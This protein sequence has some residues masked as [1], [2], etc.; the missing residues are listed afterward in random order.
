MIFNRRKKLRIISSLVILLTMVAVPLVGVGDQPAQAAEPGQLAPMNPAFL[1]FW[2]NPRP[3]PFYGYIPPPVDLSHL[4]E[5]PVERARELATFPSSFDWRDTGKV[6]SVKNQNSCGT[7][8]VHGTLAAVESKVLIEESIS[9][10]PDY[11]EQNLACCTDPAWVYL[12][13]NRCMGGGWSWLAAD[14]LTKKGT[15]LESCQPY[16]KN[17]ID[18][19][20][21][22]DSCQ[23]IKMVTD[24]RIIAN[25]ATS[26]DVIEPIKNAI[27]NHGPLAMSYAADDGSH[28][29][30]GNIYYWP[31]CP[32][33]EVNHLVCIIGWDDSIAWPGGAGSGAWIVKNSWGTDWEANGY[34]YL[35]YGSA[36]MC[37]VASLD[38]KDYDPNEKVYYWDEAGTVF[39]AGV[40]CEASSAWM[41]NIFSSTQDG[42]LSHVDFWTTSNNAQYEIYV[43][44]D[45]NISD[46]L[47]NLAASQSGSCDEFGYYSTPLTSPVSLTN[48]QPFTIAVKTTTP[49]YVYPIPVEMQFVQ[50][51]NTICDPPIQSGVSYARCSD[52]DAWED[53]ATYDCNACL[54]ARVTT[55]AA[56]QPDITV[57]PTSF[58]KTLAPDTTQDYTLNIGN[59][60][61]ATLTYTI[62]DEDES[63]PTA[64][65][66]AELPA[67]QIREGQGLMELNPS[68]PMSFRTLPT[69]GVEIAYDDGEADDAYAWDYAGDGFAV[70]FTPPQ[71][72]VELQV[73]RF[74]FWPEWPDGNHEE[75]AVE[76]YDDDGPGGAPGTLLG[77]GNTI[78]SGWGWCDVDI[79]SLGITITSGD[80]YIAYVQLSDYPN[81]EGL[82]EDYTEPDGRSWDY[83]WGEWYLWEGSDYMIRCVVELGG[84]ANNPPN[85][86]SNPSPVN[87]ATGVSISA[88]LSWTGGDPD[89]GDTVTYD[90]YFGTGASPSLVSNDQTATSYDPGTLSSDT[91]YYWKIVATD[92]HA[93]S[94]TGPVWDFTTGGAAE[95]CPWL[96][97]DP[98]SGSV[99]SGDPVDSITV[100]IN[101]TGLA[102]GDY[103]ANIVID[104]NDPDED[105][106]IVPVTL[107]VG[108]ATTVVVDP[109]SKTVSQGEQFTLDI[110]VT[111]AVAIAGAQCNISFDP[112]LIT[113]DAVAEGNLLSQGGAGTFFM[114]G[115]I[116]NVAGTITGMAGAITTPG[117]EVLTQGVFATVTFTADAVNGDTPITLSDVIVGDAGGD[118]VAVEVTNGSVTVS[119]GLIGDVNGDGHVNVLDLVLI[120]Q[121]WG[122]TGTPGWIPE[123][124]KVDGVINVLD[125]VLIGQHWTG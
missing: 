76:A 35:C 119:P 2:Q 1:E 78:A 32:Q 20:A 13:G 84:G 95:D 77:G 4:D 99:A 93:A 118:P 11:S 71:Y 88:D 48:G 85:T 114:A 8:W 103:S 90:V 81:C 96:S 3:E 120:G 44:L 82:C 108:A 86:P 59:T 73:A 42:S 10:A 91:K 117:A 106:K 72:P 41:A 38:Y 67:S 111:P 97:E 56:E 83:W 24:Y 36:S 29:H 57:S 55:G 80:F 125:M 101:T 25:E 92:N 69:T 19:E 26:P 17:T 40:G 63:G 98:T 18:A 110:L 100:S 70:R 23:S 27:L 21:C 12:I 107:H 34:F 65:A 7:C 15:R 66:E 28:M 33:S 45:G 30:E 52:A 22:D 53:L 50:E 58:E 61:D 104:N 6:T 112:S 43:Y 47:Q 124:V 94:T 46:G 54:R 49:G 31:D 116:D 60:G 123:D 89:V 74:C 62:S 37:E 51:G 79:S 68:E 122:E 5:I 115:T 39:F 87:H 16:N 75:F 14:T 105:P 102:E 64:P 9:P 121:H 109:A 113:A